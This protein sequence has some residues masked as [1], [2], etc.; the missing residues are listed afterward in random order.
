[1]NHIDELQ[2]VIHKLHGGKATHVHSVPVKETFQGK[3]VWDGIVEV[4]DLH[5][6]P[7]ANRIYALGARHGQSCAPEAA[8]YRAAYSACRIPSNRSQGSNRAGAKGT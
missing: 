2:E 5:G 7:R 1:M 6:H 8:C 3:T 4:F